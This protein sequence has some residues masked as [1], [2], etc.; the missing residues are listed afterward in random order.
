MVVQ[1]KIG[2][3]VHAIKHATMQPNILIQW[4]A[5]GLPIELPF[6]YQPT[7]TPTNFLVAA[8]MVACVTVP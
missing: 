6:N 2:C 7:S 3:M 5:H 4:V 8:T 1:P